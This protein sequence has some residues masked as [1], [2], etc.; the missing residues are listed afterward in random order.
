MSN[1]PEVIIRVVM[2]KTLA[3][4][5]NSI[6]STVIIAPVFGQLDESMSCCWDEKNDCFSNCEQC[7]EGLGY[8]LG[9]YMKCGRR[10][11]LWGS[12]RRE[13]AGN[14]GGRGYEGGLVIL[15]TTREASCTGKALDHRMPATL[16]CDTSTSSCI[17]GQPFHVWHW[18]CSDTVTTSFN[19]CVRVFFNE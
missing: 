3:I 19:R 17:K 12:D 2:I 4:Y 14:V 15:K 8:L 5:C 11:G 18:Y 16:F 9:P 13:A 10:G 6:L 7:T 1:S